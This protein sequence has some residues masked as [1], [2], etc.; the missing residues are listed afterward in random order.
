MR[1]VKVLL[2]GVPQSLP[3]GQSQLTNIDLAAIGRVEVLRGSA[4]SLYGNGSGGVISF[5]SDLSA[6]DPIGASTRYLRGS[7]GLETWAGT[8][9]GSLRLRAEYT[10]TTCTFTQEQPDYDCAYRNGV[11]PQGYTFRRRIIGHSLDNDSRMYSLG[12]VLVRNSGDTLSVTLRHVEFNR[13]G[14]GDHAF[15]SVPYDLD[16]VELRYSRTFGF[17]KLSLGFGHDQT[18]AAGV[19]SESRAFVTLQQGF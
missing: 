8:G 10:D 16:N 2:D 11:Y 12:A 4:S 18:G 6:P 7:F 9:L 13:D 19:D 3:D 17:G 1:G 14:T 5:T 15:A